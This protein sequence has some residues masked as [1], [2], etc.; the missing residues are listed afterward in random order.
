VILDPGRPFIYMPAED[1]SLVSEQV[2]KIFANF[3]NIE[4]MDICD[5]Y[6]R[7]CLIENT[8]EFVKNNLKSP[9]AVKITIT[10]EHQ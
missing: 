10:D 9:F 2:N 1:F 8:C 7:N 4:R 3:K 6:N 5:D